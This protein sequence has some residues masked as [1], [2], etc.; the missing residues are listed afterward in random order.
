MKGFCRQNVL[1]LA[2]I[3]RAPTANV[4]VRQL[5][6]LIIAPNVRGFQLLYSFTGGG[7]FTIQL[8]QRLACKTSGPIDG[9][10]SHRLA[11]HLTTC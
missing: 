4:L 5:E 8:D 10:A 6:Q 11:L 1:I 2:E 3:S 9:T 7:F